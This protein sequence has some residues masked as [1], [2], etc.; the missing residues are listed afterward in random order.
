MRLT[1][2]FGKERAEIIFKERSKTKIMEYLKRKTQKSNY[3]PKMGKD[4]RPYHEGYRDR[5]C[6]LLKVKKSDYKLPWEK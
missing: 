1:K 2:K 4:I 5:L 6:E 3:N